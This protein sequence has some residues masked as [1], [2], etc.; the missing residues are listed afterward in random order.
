M[1][2]VVFILFLIFTLCFI[3]SCNNNENQNTDNENN[4]NGNDVSIVSTFT[5]SFENEFGSDIKIII[6]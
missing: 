3:S 5:V 4:D 6:T 2:K 1:R